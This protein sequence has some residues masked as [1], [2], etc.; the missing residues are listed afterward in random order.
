MGTGMG[1]VI[2]DMDT[3][4]AIMGM[5]MGT[6]DTAIIIIIIVDLGGA[7][8]I[9]RGALEPPVNDGVCASQ[10]LQDSPFKLRKARGLTGAPRCSAYCTPAFRAPFVQ[11]VLMYQW[12]E[13]YDKVV[14]WYT[15]ASTP[16]ANQL[17]YQR[18][19]RRACVWSQLEMYSCLGPLLC[20]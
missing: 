6:M 17:T 14:T 12:V 10:P 1:M 8:G 4:T 2:M 15:T 20:R 13:V 3:G 16:Q 19:S 7:V 11:M 5:G 9:G 18:R